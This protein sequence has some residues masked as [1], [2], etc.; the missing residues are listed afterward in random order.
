MNKTFRNWKI[1]IK[2]LRIIKKVKLTVLINK[3]KNWKIK[4]NKFK[5][6]LMKNQN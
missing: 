1:K 5:Y 2:N 3:K 6:R 4:L